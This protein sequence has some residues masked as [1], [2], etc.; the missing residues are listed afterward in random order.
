VRNEDLIEEL[1]RDA[2]YI[3]H[4]AA[5]VGV[6]LIIE[7]PTETQMRAVTESRF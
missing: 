4:L 5:S 7:R 3:Y 6:Q 1:V 2:D